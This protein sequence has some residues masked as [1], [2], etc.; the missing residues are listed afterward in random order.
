MTAKPKNL[1]NAA[2]RNSCEGELECSNQLLGNRCW[3]SKDC[4]ESRLL[5]FEKEYDLAT[6]K[7]RIFE[8]VGVTEHELLE[9]WSTIDVGLLDKTENGER[10]YNVCCESC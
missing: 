5:T 8:Q 2:N 3:P 4:L 10:G 6:V 9:E 1:V 7:E